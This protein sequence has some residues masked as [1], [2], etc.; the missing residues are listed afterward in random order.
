MAPIVERLYQ[1]GA[2]KV[3]IEYGKIGQGDVLV[4]L[5]VVMPKDPAARQKVIALDPEL[6]QLQQQRPTKEF[7]QKYLYYSID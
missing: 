4:A 5:I 6:S 3:V 2:D 1:A 7:G